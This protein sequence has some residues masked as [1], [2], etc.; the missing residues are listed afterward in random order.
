MNEDILVRHCS[1]T[2]VGLKTGNMFTYEFENEK[3]RKENIRMLNRQLGKKGI[4]VIPLRQKNKKTL[5]YVYRPSKLDKDLQ[6]SFA[7]NLLKKMGYECGNSGRCLTE[8]VKRLRY[9]EQFPHEV[10]LFLGYPPED[11][12]GFINNNASDSKCCG[13]WKVYGDE[14]KAKQTFEKYKKCTEICCSLVKKGCS[15]EQLAVIC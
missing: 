9:S 7:K 8:L 1:P 6:D 13:C 10:G 5:L 4:R 12:C 14:N 2:L 3:E 15:A 11:V